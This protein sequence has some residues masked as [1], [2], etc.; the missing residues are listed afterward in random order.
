M[1]A[2]IHT[3]FKRRIVPPSKK[4][5]SYALPSTTR[6]RVHS[7]QYGGEVELSELRHYMNGVC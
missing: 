7:S 1:S 3:N 5:N 6:R 2:E 4:G